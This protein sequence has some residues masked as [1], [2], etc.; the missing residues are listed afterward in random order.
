MEANTFATTIYARTPASRAFEYLRRLQ[1]LDE[2][3]ARGV[4]AARAAVSPGP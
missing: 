4:A 2:W 3:V 1:N